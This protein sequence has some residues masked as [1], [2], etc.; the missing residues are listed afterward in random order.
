MVDTVNKSAVRA[1]PR[2]DG[3]DAGVA[4]P[5][6]TLIAALADVWASLASLGETLTAADWDRPTECP[7]WTVKDQYAHMIGTE[8]ALL[9]ERGPG[10]LAAPHAKN[11]MGEL[12][13]GWVDAWRGRSGPEVLDGFRAVTQQRLAALHALAPSDWEA[14]TTTPVGPG[15]YGL[16]MEIRAFD[17]WVH[18]QDIRRAVGRP[19]H[20]DA[21]VAELSMARVT[22]T[23]AFV[24]G[25]R[26]G[27]PDRT[28]VAVSLSAPLAQS[29]AVE[30]SG[31]RARPCPPPPSPT[32]R[33]RT[34][35]ETW[36]RLGTGRAEA[37]G[38][39]VAFEGDEALGRSVLGALSITP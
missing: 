20:F 36:L 9:G 11:P 35:G 22:G 2:P 23:F 17:C 1:F 32:V 34:D 16:F 8:S 5:S 14:P 3:H 4:P 15:T 25:K 7:G 30:V 12:N 31:G 13:E 37:S 29:F 39:T 38:A 21:P 6:D 33:I 26:V 24:V 27:A 10:P 28:T 19:G 18:E